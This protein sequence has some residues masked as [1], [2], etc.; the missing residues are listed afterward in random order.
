LQLTE[1]IKAAG[2]SP[3]ID[4]KREITARDIGFEKTGP[5]GQSAVARR[6]SAAGGKVANEIVGVIEIQY[7]GRALLCVARAVPN[8]GQGE[9]HRGE[10]ELSF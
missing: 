1:G 6:L 8:R 10:G 4:Q 2:K 7:S 3:G 9:Y 5:P